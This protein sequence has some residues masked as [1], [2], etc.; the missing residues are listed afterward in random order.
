MG[1]HPLAL[2]MIIVFGSY[3]LYANYDQVFLSIFFILIFLPFGEKIYIGSIDMPFIRIIILLI[4]IKIIL[5]NST[6][7]FKMK[8]VDY[9]FLLYASSRVF[10][11]CITVPGTSA[12]VYQLGKAFDEIGVF[13]AFRIIILDFDSIKNIPKILFSLSIPLLFFF[14]LEKHSGYNIFSIF[15]GVPE[16]TMAREGK[17]RVQGAFSHPIL[18]GTFWALLTPFMGQYIFSLNKKEKWFGILGIIIFLL[19]IVQTASSTP[20]MVFAA[21]VFSFILYKWRF[22]L[23]ELK[24]LI[25]GGCILF[26]IVFQK[27]PYALIA[28]IDITGGSTGWHRYAIIQNAFLHISDWA[29]AGMGTVS[30]EI[31]GPGLWDITNQFIIIAIEGG[32]VPLSLYIIVIY[33]SFSSLSL[34]LKK[35]KV[36]PEKVRELWSIW[37]MLF[38]HIVAM[39]VISYFGQLN[40]IFILTLAIAISAG[41][42]GRNNTELI[43]SS[44]RSL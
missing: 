7:N 30:T 19:L 36:F 15:G 3:V 29:F 23:K 2:L 1:I 24:Y 9:F 40:L 8:D 22:K 34:G 41:D 21:G 17:L 11:Y 33:K 25:I 37:V 5:C 28:Q 42:S 27:P 32:I 6:V 31:W 12:L 14:L 43:L 39:M 4:W 26:V 35:M 10:F 44:H 16:F 18:A 38:M 13:F 20:Y